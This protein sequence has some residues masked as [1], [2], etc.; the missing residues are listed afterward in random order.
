M[1]VLLSGYFLM[2]AQ[3][4]SVDLL[5]AQGRHRLRGW[6]NLGEG[7]ANLALSVYWGRHYGLIGIALGTAAPMIF[8]QVFI[9]PWYAL[10]TITLSPVRYLREAL[11]GP[12]LAAAIVLGLCAMLRPWQHAYSAGWLLL[13]VAW[14][15]ALFI[16]MAWKLAMTAD[17]RTQF[18][19]RVREMRQ[20]VREGSS[21]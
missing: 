17:E 6:W 7:A 2:L 21:R 19:K 1:L 20:V 8:V 14:Q 13:S 18:A 10:R 11:L 3:Q 4:P 9:Q 5:L 15:A 16:I 12:A